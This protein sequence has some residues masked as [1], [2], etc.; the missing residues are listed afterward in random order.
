MTTRLREAAQGICN[1]WF[2][3]DGSGDAAVADHHFD[4]LRAALAEPD[5]VAA[6]GEEV[7]EL[8]K[9]AL[10][11][12]SGWDDQTIRASRISDEFTAY[13]NE[14]EPHYRNR[15]EGFREGV[16][17][18]ARRVMRRSGIDSC[19]YDDCTKAKEMAKEIRSLAP[20]TAKE[21]EP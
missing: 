4:R 12:E 9:R 18:S 5:E 2:G 21:N 11:S 17:A 16:E 13:R 19:P 15:A 1:A 10:R 14:R 3:D 6:L 20:S 8:T 7:E